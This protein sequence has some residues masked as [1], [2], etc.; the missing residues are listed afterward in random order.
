MSYGGRGAPQ[1]NDEQ[2]VMQT[3]LIKMTMSINKQCFL[4]CVS[5][6]KDDKLSQQEG[7]CIEMCAKRQSGAFQAMNDIQGQL[8]SRGAGGGMF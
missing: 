5:N 8:Q 6:F 4:E 2:E 3:M 7:S 1:R